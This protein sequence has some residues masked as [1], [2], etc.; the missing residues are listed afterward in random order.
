MKGYLK[1]DG[2]PTP[3]KPIKIEAK[4]PMFVDGELENFDNNIHSII[5]EYSKM[6]FKEK[7]QILTQRIIMKQEQEIERL[8]NIINNANKVLQ[9]IL[10]INNS[11]HKGK[12][13]PIK[14]TSKN[15]VYKSVCMLYGIL[16]TPY[17]CDYGFLQEL[18]GDGSNE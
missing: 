2:E 7:D 10:V 15:D 16:G 6:M 3:D 4:I 13:R 11:E 18:K 12:Y 17:R 1:Q 5:E 9:N 8:N 14:N